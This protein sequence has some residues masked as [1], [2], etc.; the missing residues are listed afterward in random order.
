MSDG[1]TWI[2]FGINWDRYECEHNPS[3]RIE[4][5]FINIYNHIMVHRN[6]K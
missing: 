2:S 4:L 1:V 6:G 5:T 3:F